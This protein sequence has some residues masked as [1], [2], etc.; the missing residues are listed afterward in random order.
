LPLDQVG[1]LDRI[2]RL[3]AG[4]RLRNLA[5]REAGLEHHALLDLDR[6]RAARG[7][8]AAA[9]WGDR[10][11]IARRIHRIVAVGRGVVDALP[12]LA[13]LDV[14]L[15]IAVDEL[16]LLVGAAVLLL[17]RL[18]GPDDDAAQRPVFLDRL[19]FRGARVLAEPAGDLVAFV[20]KAALVPLRHFE[21]EVELA[22][23]L[24]EVGGAEVLARLL[25]L[26]PFLG[27]L[28]AAGGERHFAGRLLLIGLPLEG[29]EPV[30]LAYLQLILAEVLGNGLLLKPRSFLEG[31][32]RRIFLDE[33]NP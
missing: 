17:G 32:D 14:L 15:N 2:R 22:L 10:L 33:L 6:H 24:V 3:D 8:A 16:L 18:A 20:L 5:R 21:F 27:D 31:V 9:V 19:D 26:Q 25:G 7:A 4:E 28:V 29:A 1:D 30:G 12:G 11:C 23:E 13:A